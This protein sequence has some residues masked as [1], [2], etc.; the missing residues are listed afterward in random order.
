MSKKERHKMEK[1]MQA[2][3]ANVV[4]PAVAPSSY[5]TAAKPTFYPT[6]ATPFPT[7]DGTY[8]PTFVVAEYDGGG[9]WAKGGW[10]GAFPASWNEGPSG[11]AA[12]A[13]VVEGVGGGGG[14]GGNGRLLAEGRASSSFGRSSWASVPPNDEFFVR[15]PEFRARQ[16]EIYHLRNPPA[17]ATAAGAIARGIDERNSK[18]GGRGIAHSIRRTRDLQGDDGGMTIADIASGNPDFSILLAAAT[19]AGFQDVLS[20]GGPVTVFGTC[21]IIFSFPITRVCP[22]SHCNPP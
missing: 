1:M 17:S 14:N 4:V 21:E 8:P 2:K 13:P 9:K 5:A 15:F 11:T 16:E 22:F 19:A 3:N 10:N 12:S 18:A 20:G 6:F 7:D